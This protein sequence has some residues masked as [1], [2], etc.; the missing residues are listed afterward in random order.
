MSDIDREIAEK[1]DIDK[2]P[3][4]GGTNGYEYTLTESHYMKG[5]WGKPADGDDA[6]NIHKS[7]AACLDCGKKFRVDTC[8]RPLAALKTVEEK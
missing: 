2:C 8:E 7:L 6:F 5:A 1:I 3:S 4:C